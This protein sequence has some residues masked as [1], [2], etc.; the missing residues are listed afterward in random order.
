ME[1][2]NRYEG[3]MD[4]YYLPSDQDVANWISLIQQAQAEATCESI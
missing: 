3:M 2:S 4:S 1:I